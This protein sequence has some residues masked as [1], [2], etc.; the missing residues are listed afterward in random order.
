MGR[1]GLATVCFGSFKA[2]HFGKDLAVTTE[3]KN[4][5]DTDDTA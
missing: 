3:K 1:N 5:H 4:S 2:M